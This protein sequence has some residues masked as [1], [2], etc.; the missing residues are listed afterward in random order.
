MS[1]IWPNESPL[2]G[3]ITVEISGDG[4]WNGMIVMFG[5]SYASTKLISDQVVECVVPPTY[6]VGRVAVTIKEPYGRM[7]PEW[8]G[9]P[10]PLTFWYTRKTASPERHK[11]WKKPESEEPAK[12]R[13]VK[14]SGDLEQPEFPK[15][16]EQEEDEHIGD[17]TGLGIVACYICGKSVTIKSKR[18]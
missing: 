17:V 6:S 12:S 10:R 4:F 1:R 3:G 15:E 14:A 13:S 8:R 2:E 11:P 9:P 16:A 7:M 5:F 18:D